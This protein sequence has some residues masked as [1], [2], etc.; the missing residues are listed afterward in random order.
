ML[1]CRPNYYFKSHGRKCILHRIGGCL[2]A[3]RLLTAMDKDT[4][5]LWLPP[6][7]KSAENIS[8]YK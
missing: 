6:S 1:D 8:L 4:Q 7:I 2:P 3:V 5:R